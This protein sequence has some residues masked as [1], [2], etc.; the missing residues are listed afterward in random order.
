MAEIAPR[1]LTG[2][3]PGILAMMIEDTDQL[4]W[5]Q[6]RQQLRLESEARHFMTR[7]EARAVVAITCSSRQELLGPSENE[8]SPCAE[9][10]FRNPNHPSAKQPALAPAVMSSP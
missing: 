6:L 8:G 10:R 7:P 5:H 3:R 2:T 4:E 9:L 1:C